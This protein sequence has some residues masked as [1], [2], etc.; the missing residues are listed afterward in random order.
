MSTHVSLARTNH[1]VVRDLPAFR[2]AMDPYEV[3][4]VEDQ[5]RENRVTVLARDGWP[6]NGYDEETDEDIEVDLLGLISEHL[7]PGQVTVVTA[8]GHEKMRYMTGW[9]G[10][11]NSEGERVS[12]DLDDIYNLAKPLGDGSPILS[13]AY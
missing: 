6:T 8:S 3:E 12:L 5:S 4:I 11:I 13:A 9:A 2:A 7:A 10:A 1:F